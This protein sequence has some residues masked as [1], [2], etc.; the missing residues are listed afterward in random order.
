MF[1]AY[2]LVAVVVTWPLL[3]VFSTRF[4]GHPFGDSY[5]YASSIWWLK[6]ALQTGAP[7]FYQPLLAYPD[8]LSATFL[9]SVPLQS[10]PAALLFFVLPLPAAFNLSVLLTL[11]L[12]GWAAYFLAAHLTG[13]RAAAWVS[14]LVFMAYPTF[15]GHLAAG[16]SG[17]LHQ[18]PVPLY[19]Y[20]LLHVRG[21]GERRW[22]ALG[23]LFFVLSLLGSSLNLIYVLFPVTALFLLSLLFRREWAA[24]RRALV[25]VFLGGLLWLIFFLPVLS[26]TLAA[27]DRPREG[28]SV[29]FS[30]D[31]LA[32]IAPSFQHPLFSGLDYPRRV[33]GIDPFEKMAYIGIVA[34]ALGLLAVWR[35]PASRGWLLLGL[36][37]W[38]LALGPVLKLFDAPV[39]RVVGGYATLVTLPWIAAQNLPLLDISRTPARFNFTLALVVAVLAG[40]GMNIILD[41]VKGWRTQVRYRILAGRSAVVLLISALILYEYPFFWANGL[42]DMP[43]LP[44]AVPPPITVL[45]DRDDVRAVFDI[46]PE[47]LLTDKEAMFLQTGHRRPL[48]AGHIARRTPVDPAKLA[49]LATLD[50]A[51]LDA[52]GADVVILHK[53]WADTGGETEAVARARLGEP[54]YQDDDYAVFFTPETDTQPAFT[55]I[56][57]SVD[58]VTDRAE[59]YIYTPM[60]GW[61]LLTGTLQADGRD[62]LL[63]LNGQRLWHG[64][65]AG[66][67]NLQMPVFLPTAGYYTLTLALEPP[68][69]GIVDPALTCRSLAVSDLGLAD[70]LTADAADQVVFANGLSL[71]A[72]HLEY[73][74]GEL[75]V[76]LAWRFDAPRAAHEIRFVHIVDESGNLVAQVDNSL[77]AQPA[78]GWSEAVRVTLPPDL[79]PGVYRVYTGWYAYP[80]TTPYPILTGAP[81]ASGVIDLGGFS[82]E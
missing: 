28:G 72:S 76:W 56:L 82:V 78:G 55:A 31:L 79:S 18:W 11:T 33:L 23:A 67:V 36:V 15:Q 73:R 41:S 3:T 6:Q 5:E 75:S 50:P 42:P 62:V 29:T 69:P 70:V 46:P 57:N 54:F 21:A 24:L 8:G 39:Q 81:D 65:I 2:L 66:T 59:S 30:A 71:A 19:I 49:L 27:S 74:A 47:H 45:A 51:L 52:A 13:S 32:V 40:Y 16:H 38:I 34:G 9:W 61:V 25:A 1:A 53:K 80:D 44:G 10:F 14:G 58:S 64:N 22:L 48:M 77:G 7:L 68:C 35:K 12:N 17:L 20:A 43:T 63:S 60:P 37:A 4:I 26:D